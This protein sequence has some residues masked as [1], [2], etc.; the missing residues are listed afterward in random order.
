MISYLVLLATCSL[1]M[2]YN[3]SNVTTIHSYNETMNDSIIFENDYISVKASNWILNST[4]RE[5]YLKEIRSMLESSVSY[6]IT[7][8]LGRE[9]TA[10]GVGDFLRAASPIY[11]LVVYSL[12]CY[13]IIR[14]R[15]RTRFF[16][17]A[18]WMLSIALI[19]LNYERLYL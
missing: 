13:G 8:L 9:L 19:L 2:L 1:T 15:R 18:I 6:L 4:R 12:A 16:S 17:T 14:Q 5:V 11:P 3:R 10:I 7:R